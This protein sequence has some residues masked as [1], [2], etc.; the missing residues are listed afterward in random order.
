MEPLIV[1][2]TVFLLALVITRI[3]KKKW[4]FPFAG[5]ITMSTL[6]LFTAAGHFVYPDGMA[7]MLPGFIPYKLEVIY[8]TGILEILAAIGLLIPR[9][10]KLTAWLLIIFFIAI[11]PANIYAAIHQ[12]NLT[13]ANYDGRG[14]NYLWFRVPLQ[15]LFIAWVYYFAIKKA[16]QN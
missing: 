10:Q 13:T 9:Y 4:L 5:R 8:V 11:L 16:G 12:V 7:L 2:I 1:L 3:I 6:L 15:L 14:L